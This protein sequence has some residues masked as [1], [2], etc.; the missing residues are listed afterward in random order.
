M[1]RSTKLLTI[2]IALHAFAGAAAAG[3][4]TFSGVITQSAQDGT[5]PAVNNTALNG[6]NDET[7]SGPIFGNNVPGKNIYWTLENLTLAYDTPGETGAL[8]TGFFPRME[9]VNAPDIEI[10]VHCPSMIAFTLVHDISLA[11]ARGVVRSPGIPPTSS[12]DTGLIGAFP[13]P[14]GG[15]ARSELPPD[16]KAG[17]IVSS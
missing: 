8:V 5:G 7:C 13:T 17:V 9:H 16:R 3:T 4:I 12:P 2:W 11:S 10:I 14:A 15:D 1:T 6:I